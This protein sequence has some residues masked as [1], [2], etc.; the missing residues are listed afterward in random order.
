MGWG[1]EPAC[2]SVIFHLH[3][4]HVSMYYPPS[5]GMLYSDS[6]LFHFFSFGPADFREKRFTTQTRGGHPVQA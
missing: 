6:M 3:T 1:C 2:K 5:Y 4:G